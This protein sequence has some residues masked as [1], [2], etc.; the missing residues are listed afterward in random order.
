MKKKIKLIQQIILVLKD[1]NSQA[2]VN[3]TPTASLDPS[4]HRAGFIVE[5]LSNVMQKGKEAVEEKCMTEI[6]CFNC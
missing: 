4:H 1:F 3:H 5:D 2:Q 6:S